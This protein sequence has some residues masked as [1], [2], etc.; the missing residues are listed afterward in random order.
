MEKTPETLMSEI[1]YRDVSVSQQD[2]TRQMEITIEEVTD[3]GAAGGSYTKVS[4]DYKLSWV[5][6]TYPATAADGDFSDVVFA[7]SDDTS[8]KLK[9][10]YLFYYPWYPASES[11]S[12]GRVVDYITINNPA[13]LDV[14]VYIVKQRLESPY[15]EMNENNYRVEVNIVEP[16]AV[17]DTEPVTKLYTNL[18][19]NLYS[20]S[21]FASSPATITLNSV[22]LTGTELDNV[23]HDMLETDSE[24]RLYDVT[25][26]T[27]SSGSY[28]A[29][30]NVSNE[31][32]F[33]NITGGTVN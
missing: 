1:N 11:W 3:S 14:N 30:F 8:R 2:V 12:S 7:N 27:Y 20:G 13:K 32:I 9:N 26:A 15:L 18:D 33:M 16:M 23:K 22:T 29:K 19:T 5:G 24:A 21:D 28:N 31:E 25:V 17:T 4:T 6:G 10:V